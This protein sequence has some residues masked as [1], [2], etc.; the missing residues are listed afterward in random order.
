MDELLAHL[1][2]SIADEVFSKNEKKTFKSLVQEKMLSPDQLNLLRSHIYE[3]ANKKV[4]PA[5]YQ[6]ILEWIKT[7]TSALTMP[8]LETTDAF[9]SPGDACRNAITQ[10]INSATFQLHIC[11]FTISD[12]SITKSL[13]TAHKKGVSIKVITDND[14]SLDI[15][16][17]IKELAQSGI[18]VKMDNSPNHMH[19]KFMVADQRTLITGS[20]NW[21]LSAARYNHEN[22][23]VT[24]E[25]NVVKSFAQQFDRLWN[26]MDEF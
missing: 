11:V 10:Q 9:F 16:S 18:A 7:A 13:L 2:S 12:D 5:N 20:Y 23:L 25:V 21:T 15:G 19:H 4:N 17:D 26:V 3:L 14:K 8:A 6:F 24:R 1:E 22:I